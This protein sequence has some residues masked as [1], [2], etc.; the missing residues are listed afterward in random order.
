M[1]RLLARLAAAN[2]LLG[3]KNEKGISP[4]FSSFLLVAEVYVKKHTK[5]YR[6]VGYGHTRQE[7]VYNAILEV[8]GEV[9][10]ISISKKSMYGDLFIINSKKGVKNYAA[11]LDLYK[12]TGGKIKGYTIEKVEKV[13]DQYKA[14][15]VLKRVKK[16]YHYKSPDKIPSKRPHLAVLPFEHKASYQIYGISID[17]KA[18]SDRLTQALI[19][20]ISQTHRFTLLD[21][22]NSKYYYLEKALLKEDKNP[23]ELSR[24]GKRLGVDYF[25]IAK[26]F[27]F[28]IDQEAGN[29]LIGTSDY[30]NRAYITISYRILNIPLQQ[31]KY[32]DT[33]DIDFEI[34]AKRRAESLVFSVAQKVANK[35]AKETIFKLYPPKVIGY[36]NKNRV[37]V[38]LGGKLIHKGDRFK[39]YALGKKLYDPYTKEYLGRDEIER[40]EI[41]V[42][43]VLPKFSYAKVIK[44]R[45]KKGYILRPIASAEKEADDDSLGRESTFEEMFP[46]R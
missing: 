17:G 33:I 35:L 43:K 19:D 29:S 20:T 18:L 22:Q 1:K 10:G 2:L 25:F 37:I 46:S 36:R 41:V 16:S 5:I 15:V 26:I 42:T 30:S 34:P 44:G 39:A 45:V 7:A 3:K 8:L 24:I 9:K 14:I 21:R 28:G 23:V 12:I 40:G 38:D 4:F 32:S 11:G 13:G 6:G 31:I 27:D